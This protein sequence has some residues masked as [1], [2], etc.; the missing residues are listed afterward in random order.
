MPWNSSVKEVQTLELNG[1]Y[2]VLNSKESP[3]PQCVCGSYRVEI[4]RKLEN[5]SVTMWP[6]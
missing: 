5:F 1:I 3:S 6:Y 4:Q 2:S